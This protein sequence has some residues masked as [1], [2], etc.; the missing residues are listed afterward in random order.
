M[1]GTAEFSFLARFIGARREPARRTGP[2]AADAGA[3]PT[4]PPGLGTPS[5]NPSPARSSAA[6]GCARAK[7]Q[8]NGRD[9]GE[10]RGQ[11]PLPSWTSKWCGVRGTGG[12]QGPAGKR[13]KVGE[14][15]LRSPPAR[16][17]FLCDLP[18]GVVR[19]I[20]AVTCELNRMAD[21]IAH[22]TAGNVAIVREMGSDAPGGMKNHGGLGVA[23]CTAVVARVYSSVT[24]QRRTIR[25]GNCHPSGWSN[26]TEILERVR[27]VLRRR[28]P[29]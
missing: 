24:P 23:Y 15:V 27:H 13:G 3:S 6:R 8:V 10:R 1:K 2:H 5:S 22:C 16:N 25:R 4:L 20:L 17:D 21:V 9:E 26:R 12:A 11:R 29:R 28:L 7:P 18:V 19:M 14:Q